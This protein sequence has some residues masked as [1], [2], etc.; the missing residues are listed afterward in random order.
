[1]APRTP[2]GNAVSDATSLG[3]EIRARYGV[4]REFDPAEFWADQAAELRSTVATPSP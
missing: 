4:P 1:V 3:E 2:N